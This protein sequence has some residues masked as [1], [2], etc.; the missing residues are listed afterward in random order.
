MRAA[1]AL[2]REH[3]AALQVVLGPPQLLLGQRLALQ[4]PDLLDGEAHHL[5]ARSRGC[6]PA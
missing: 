3:E 4:A 6:V 5:V 2:E 1:R